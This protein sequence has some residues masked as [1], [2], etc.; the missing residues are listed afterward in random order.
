MLRKVRS[1]PYEM[2]LSFS[3]P[4]ALLITEV[5]TQNVNILLPKKIIQQA[6]FSNNYSVWRNI[7]SWSTKL[8]SVSCMF[9]PRKK[10]NDLLKKSFYFLKAFVQ[11]PMP[12]PEDH[13]T[14]QTSNLLQRDNLWPRPA[15]AP[16]RGGKRYMS[17]GGRFADGWKKYSVCK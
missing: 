1:F 9:T 4:L 11:D 3:P 6:P 8:K 10:I 5:N 16:A 15:A 13:W 7:K 14:F 12:P 2:P 17:E